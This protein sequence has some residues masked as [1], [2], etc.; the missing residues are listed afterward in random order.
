V[1]VVVPLELEVVVEAVVESLEL[2]VVLVEPLVV[3]VV[4]PPPPEPPSSSPQAT[5]KH[6]V[7]PAAMRT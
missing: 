6:A 4:V 1:L 2:L 3:D 5:A 7:A